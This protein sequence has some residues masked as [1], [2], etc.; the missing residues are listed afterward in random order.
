MKPEGLPKRDD[1]PPVPTVASRREGDSA[2]E[3][4][5]RKLD[6][7]EALKKQKELDEIKLKNLLMEYLFFIEKY[8][9]NNA[10]NKLQ[11]HQKELEY[12]LR[13]E[14]LMKTQDL[15]EDLKKCIGDALKTGGSRANSNLFGLDSDVFFERATQAI[16]PNRLIWNY[17]GFDPIDETTKKNEE[18]AQ[19]GSEAGQESSPEDGDGV[20]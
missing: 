20:G 5:K 11:L 16:W 1:D 13:I 10:P 4:K 19:D 6:E 18:P 17:I 14:N 7:D 12:R 15:G 2:A 3:I 8:N 9:M